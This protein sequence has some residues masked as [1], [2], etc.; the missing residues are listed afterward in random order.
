MSA[1]DKIVGIRNQMKAKSIDAYL[2]GTADPHQSEYPPSYWQTRTWIS[3]FTGSAGTAVITQEHIGLWTDV[4]YFL[5]AETELAVSGFTLHKL[6]VQTQAEYIDWLCSNLKS[7]QVV[8]CDFQCFSLG[9]IEQFDRLFSE[10][11]IILKDSGDLFETIW[12]DRPKLSE[13]AI[14]EHEAKFAGKSRKEKLKELRHEMEKAGADFILLSALDEV[15][16]LLNLRGKDVECNP[17]FIGYVVVEKKNTILFINSRKITPE[18]K[19][20]LEKDGIS[21][22]PYENISQYISSI[23]NKKIWIDQST[24]NAKLALALPKN[25]MIAKP[26]AVMLSKAVK[27]EKECKHIRQ[28]MAKDGAALVKAF[29]WLEN[30]LKSGKNPTEYDLAQKIASSRASMPHY[31][32]ESFFAIVGYRGNGAIIH[33][34]PDERTSSKIKPEGVLLIDSGGQYLDGTTDITR[35]IALSEVSDDIKSHYTAVLKGHIDVCKLVFTKG[36]KGIQIDAFARQHLWKL[37][38]NYGHGTGHGVGFFMNVHEP[39]QGIVSAWNQRGSSELLPGMLTS[40]EPGFYKE[41]SHGIR[42][43]NL[44]LTIAHA[45]DFLAFENVTLFPIDTKLIDRKSFGPEYRKWL[46]DY[47]KR[48]YKKISPMLDD[49]Q[50]QWLKE[51]CSAY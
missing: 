29:M 34:R 21:L 42:I 2:V 33:Y 8:G 36:T 41:G 19:I 18:L 6:L 37:G 46:N 51:K 9:Q 7:G 20:I 35:T 45:N 32:S 44:V 13:A 30:E 50:K 1:K 4:R 22:M 31:V 47:H 10:K 39:P 12:K 3:G 40:N 48:C 17:V 28:V 38:L 11:G 25:S 27:N 26:S 43:E 5:Q 14:Y 49:E 16:H 23:S 15:A 24:M